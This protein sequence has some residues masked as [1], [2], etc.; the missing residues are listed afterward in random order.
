MINEYFYLNVPV[1]A[2]PAP[3]YKEARQITRHFHR[4]IPGLIPDQD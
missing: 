2:T 4:N 1:A 3:G